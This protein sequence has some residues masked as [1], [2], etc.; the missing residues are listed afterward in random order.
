MLELSKRLSLIASHVNEG[1]KVCDVGTD[2]G[3]LPAFLYL[4]GK[5]K[6]VCATDINEKPLASAKSNIERLGAD[7]VRLVLCDGLAGVTRDDADTVIIAG[8]GGE[9]ISGI[10]SRAEFLRDNTV[11]LVLQPTTA[12]KELRQFLAQNGF[13]VERETAIAENGKIYS[14]MAVRFSGAPYDISDVQSLI[15]ILTPTDDDA[16]AYIQKQYRIA[17]K[18]ADQLKCAANKQ[19]EY[20]Y[21]LSLSE[22]LKNILGG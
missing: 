19:D 1:S 4:S 10:I 9:V 22:K 11:S 7:G 14:V 21:Y 18:C 13:R 12:A 2:H 20:N 17:Q 8:M 16:I 6:S 15:G 3:Y 5:C